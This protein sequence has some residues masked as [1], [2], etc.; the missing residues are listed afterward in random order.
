MSEITADKLNRF[1]Y[2]DAWIQIAC[3]R[4][5]IDWGHEFTK[6]LLNPY[7]SYFA[8]GEREPLRKSENQPLKDIEYTMDF[9][10]KDSAGPWSVNHACLS[11]RNR[12]SEPCG[13]CK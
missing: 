7:E 8:L 5:S 3:P 1:D 2:I 9:Y 6:P 11:A 12:P 4:L 13:F 10:R